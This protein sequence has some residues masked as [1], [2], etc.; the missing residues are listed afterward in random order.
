MKYKQITFYFIRGEKFP[1][2]DITIGNK[3]K[4]E[5]YISLKYMG[6]TKKNK[7]SKNER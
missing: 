3:K 5:G 4:C 1:N 2:M 7:N 6:I